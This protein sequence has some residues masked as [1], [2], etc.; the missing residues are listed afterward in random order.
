MT[1]RV[2]CVGIIPNNIILNKA[3]VDDPAQGALTRIPHPT[4]SIRNLSHIII[5]IE[6]AEINQFIIIYILLYNM[7]YAYTV[8]VDYTCWLL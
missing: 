2:S 1:S 3:M 6:R 8:Q 7:R 5:L 4:L